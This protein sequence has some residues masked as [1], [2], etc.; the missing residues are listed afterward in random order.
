MAEG[1]EQRLRKKAQVEL[2]IKNLNVL[3]LG[4]ASWAKR[5]IKIDSTPKKPESVSLRLETQATDSTWMGLDEWQKE[6]LPKSYPKDGELKN[7]KAK[8]EERLSWDEK[9][10]A[11][12]ERE[13][14]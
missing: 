11:E 5:N 10:E 9:L 3:D 12:C 8:K 2:K 1:A 4:G 6:G 14:D 7:K 13:Q